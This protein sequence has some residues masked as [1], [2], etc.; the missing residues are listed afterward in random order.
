MSR[1]NIAKT[2][3]VLLSLGALASPLQAAP[4]SPLLAM[5]GSWSGGGTLTTSD[6]M[7]EQLRCRAKYDVDGTG[8][9]LRLSLKCASASYNFDLT[10]DVAYRGGA[11]SGA[12]TEASRNASGTI[13]GRASGDRVEAA[14]RGDNFSADLSL[15]TRGGKQSVS[16]RPQQSNVT[17]VS[18]TLARH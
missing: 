5:A 9:E 18:L 8:A 11:I 17:A 13:S 3:L 4:A 14:A 1:S 10:S 7:Q 16:I 15:T 12:W 6:G 2:S